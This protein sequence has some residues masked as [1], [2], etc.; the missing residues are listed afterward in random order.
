NDLYVSSDFW[1]FTREKLS[2]SYNI[3][4]PMVTFSLFA[5]DGGAV[6]SVGTGDE[7]K[8]TRPEAGYLLADGIVEGLTLSKANI[9]DNP[10]LKHERLE[11]QLPLFLAP[12]EEYDKACKKIEEGINAGRSK[13]DDY[14]AYGMYARYHRQQVDPFYIAFCHAISLGDTAIGTAPFEV[15]L[16]FGLEMKG[17]ANYGQVFPVQIVEQSDGYLRTQRIINYP[18]I[19]I[20]QSSVLVSPEGGKIMINKIVNKLNEWK[21]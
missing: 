1:H 20:H 6:K 19:K 8:Y 4:V 21:K 3:K 18:S 15:D 10:I 17:R 16:P 11:M 13:C 12:K 9:Y 14:Y 5:G 2:Q 7:K